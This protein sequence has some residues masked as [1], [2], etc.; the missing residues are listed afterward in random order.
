MGGGE[1]GSG[2]Q[3]PY[4]NALRK[5]GAFE[6]ITVVNGVTDCTYE[7][8]PSRFETLF[9][10]EVYEVCAAS[11]HRYRAV[12]PHFCIFPKVFWVS[13]CSKTPSG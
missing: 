9:T 13:S 12:L 5:G 2:V 10:I 6:S 3:N 7:A 11:N 4:H 8:Y 1:G